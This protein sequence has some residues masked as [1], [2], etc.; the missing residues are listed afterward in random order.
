MNA[1][2]IDDTPTRAL[3][4]PQGWDYRIAHGYDQVDF[5]LKHWPIDIVLLDHDMPLLCGAQVATMFRFE[6]ARYPIVVLSQNE[7]G[8]KQ[9]VAELEELTNIVR[10]PFFG[11]DEQWTNLVERWYEATKG[12]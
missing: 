8:A 9:I 2:L 12:P 7:Y 1:L 6:L 10:I 11:G 3:Y 5:W 4:L